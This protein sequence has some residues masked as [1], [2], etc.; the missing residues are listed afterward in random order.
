VSVYLHAHLSAFA[1]DVRVA[2]D[3]T[4]QARR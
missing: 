4:D 2:G 1:I 3:A